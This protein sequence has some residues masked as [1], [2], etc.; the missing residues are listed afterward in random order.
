MNVSGWSEFR[1]RLTY[2][3]LIYFVYFIRSKK[4]I[5][6]YINFARYL[7]VGACWRGCIWLLYYKVVPSWQY[8]PLRGWSILT[9]LHGMTSQKT[10]TCCIRD[11]KFC[12]WP[13]R[14]C[15]EFLYCF[16]YAE[17]IF[18]YRNYILIWK[19]L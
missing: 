7:T 5:L 13:I 17:A 9:I 15:Y 19:A 10:C 8:V 14:A 12:S 1:D 3:N 11:L 2:F 18:A 16:W 6:F 4:H